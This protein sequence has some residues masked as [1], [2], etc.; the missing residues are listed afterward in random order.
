MYRRVNRLCYSIRPAR[1]WGR[2]RWTRWYVGYLQS[3]IW[4][5]KRAAVMQRANCRCER[6]L[7][8]PAREVHHLHYRRVGREHVD[9]LLAVCVYCHTVLH[10]ENN[11]YRR[12]QSD[13]SDSSFEHVSQQ[14][15]RRRYAN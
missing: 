13:W 10:A 5:A 8:A 4:A 2:V 15:R 12:F 14:R 11:E 7:A 3:P 6:C 9:D 1:C